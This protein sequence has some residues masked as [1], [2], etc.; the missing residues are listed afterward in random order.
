MDK[1]NVIDPSFLTLSGDQLAL[2]GPYFWMIG[3]ALLAMIV[4]VIRFLPSKWTVFAVAMVGIL[5]GLF[6][7]AN[8]IGMDRAD[9]FGGMMVADGFSAFFNVLFLGTAALSLCASLKYLDKEKLQYP[10]YTILLLFS[11]IGMMLMASALDLITIF[12][13]L[14]IMSLSVYVLVGFRRNDRRSNEAAMKYFI[15]GAAASAILLYGSALLYGSTGTFVIT[16]ILARISAKGD[17]MTPV[18]HLGAWMV[19]AGFLFKIASVPFHMWLP[20]V[21]EGA[22]TPITGFMTTGVKAAAFAAFIRVFVAFGYGKDLTSAVEGRLH[23]VLW[24]LAVATMFIGNVIA[25]TQTNL[26]RML[27]YSTIAHTGYLLVGMIAAPHAESGFAP[28]AMYLAVYTVMNLG[29]FAVLSVLAGRGDTGL[30]LHD[31]SGLGKRHPWLAFSLAI[32]LFSLAGIPPT[33]GF[34]SKYYLLYSAIQAKEVWLVVLAVLCSAIAV[35][36][37]LRVLVYMYMREPQADTPSA[38][39]FT[40]AAAAFAVAMMVAM[41]LQIGILPAKMMAIT[42]R[43]VAKL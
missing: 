9:L 10:E 43:V 15:L 3:A 41:T 12:I 18:F 29:A 8:Q 6:V 36:Y 4:G 34:A 22:P 5:G 40:P 14:E 24:V 2:L 20:D 16:E 23:D 25:L 35:Y 37:Y 32:F 33:A 11:T 27:A 42:K 26:K 17:L 7:S 30:N 1:L 21:Y 28:V 31:L 39:D 38:K 19:L 13:A